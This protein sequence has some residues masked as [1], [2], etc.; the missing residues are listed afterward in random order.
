MFDFLHSLFNIGRI[1]HKVCYINGCINNTVNLI[2]LLITILIL[3][4]RFHTGSS[5]QNYTT[6]NW[7]YNQLL[8]YFGTINHNVDDIKIRN[9]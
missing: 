1:N 4:P 6:Q 5:T 9:S 3:F 7:L 8:Q 2:I